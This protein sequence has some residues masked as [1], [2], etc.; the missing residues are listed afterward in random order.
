MVS[1]NGSIG[2]A[3]HCQYVLWGI[4]ILIRKILLLLV[5]FQRQGFVVLMCVGSIIKACE[6]EWVSEL[7]LVLTGR[8]NLAIE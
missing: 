2:S 5:F 1:C 8:I 7:T 6:R 4:F 3:V